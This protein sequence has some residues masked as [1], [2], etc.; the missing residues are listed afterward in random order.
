MFFLGSVIMYCRVCDADMGSFAIRRTYCE[1]VMEAWM[2]DGPGIEW[3]DQELTSRRGHSCILCHEEITAR[4]TRE[5]RGRKE[6]ENRRK[7]SRAARSTRKRKAR[8]GKTIG[9]DS[10]ASKGRPRRKLPGGCGEV[11]WSSLDFYDHKHS[12][13][14][15]PRGGF[16]ALQLAIRSSVDDLRRYSDSIPVERST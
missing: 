9:R 7:L 13:E 4:A 1:A 12:Q 15:S 16:D 2:E 14:A 10:P 3:S 11:E 8:T 5:T 6:R